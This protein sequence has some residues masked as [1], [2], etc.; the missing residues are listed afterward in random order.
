MV[1]ATVTFACSSI[2]QII[3]RPKRPATLAPF[4]IIMYLFGTAYAFAA[5]GDTP[6]VYILSIILVTSTDVLYGSRAMLISAV[7]TSSVLLT[8]A[9][10]YPEGSGHSLVSM[11]ISLVLTIGTVGMIYWLKKLNLVKVETYEKLR[12]REKMQT[13]R[14]ETVVNSLAD[15]V[16]SVDGRGTVRLY[17]SATLSLLDT[18]SNIYGVGVDK[19]F[20]LKDEHGN[21]I[22]MLDLINT[23][24]VIKRSDLILTYP[25]G[26][27][28]N[29]YL[30]ISPIHTAVHDSEQQ[31]SGAIVIARDITKQKTLDD[32]RDEFISVVSHE[33][34][35]PVAIAEGALSNMQFLVKKGIDAKTFLNSLDAAHDQIL[36]LGQMVNDLST[37]SRAQRGIYMDPENINVKNFM[38]ELYNKY[39][40]EA[41]KRHLSLDLDISYSGN[42]HIPRMPVEEIMQNLIMNALKYTVK[43]G[44][45][46][47]ARLVRETEATSANNL[48]DKASPSATAKTSAVKSALGVEFFIRDT[49]IGIS[50]SDQK[51]LFKRFWRSEDYRTRETSG[52]GLGLHVVRQLS[53]KIGTEVMVKSRLNHGSTFSFILPLEE[54]SK[55]DKQAKQA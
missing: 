42:V 32:E 14:L 18:N 34:R 5:L 8:L 1:I 47:G 53:E 48:P 41:K 21:S 28:I 13:D 3:I 19:L 52:T 36:Y 15:A 29:I 31:L 45:T 26:Q 20:E 54:D 37:L 27:Q 24:R 39:L 44:V 30:S 23:D 46:I 17:N 51:N 43:G 49:G 9:F 50:N 33:L 16:I 35:T 40:P 38:T 11:M 4:T 12:V 10:M 22:S 2:I 7:Y 55:N 6:A 25:D